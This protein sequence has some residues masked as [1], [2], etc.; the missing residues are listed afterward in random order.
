M[1]SEQIKRCPQCGY[2]Y[3][4][5]V[6]VCPDCG[7]PLETRPKLE[8]IPG[9]LDRTTN[10]RWTVV[11]N[12][13]NA[14][15]G[16]FVK[17]QLEDAGIP[18]LMFRSRS[19]DIAE[20]SHNDFVPHDLL[21]PLHRFREARS[22]IESA[23]GNDYGPRLWDAT[24]SDDEQ[25]AE[26]DEAREGEETGP[27]NAAAEEASG[28]PK[29][30]MLLPT[31]ADLD[32]LQQVRRTH[33]ESLKGWYWSDQTGKSQHANAR[34]YEPESDDD[35]YDDRENPPSNLVRRLPASPHGRKG[36]ANDWTK[37]SKW[38]RIFYGAMILVMSLPFIF[39]LLQEAWSILGRLR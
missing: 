30:W 18:V 29:G 5:W 26:V 15:L 25:D 21:V 20:F 12:V 33:G 35:Y 6:D 2:E 14:I 17:G 8:V 7:T 4:K 11:T 34:S 27:N 19:A 39:Q 37:P 16:N 13:P 32:S 22:L 23:P 9:K 10:P 1:A 3:E 38:V 24:Y 36:Y 28:M 31:E